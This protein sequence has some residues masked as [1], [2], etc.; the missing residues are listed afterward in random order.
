MRPTLKTVVRIRYI[1]YKHAAHSNVPW[2]ATNCSMEPIRPTKKE[3][4]RMVANYLLSI[5]N[6][7]VTLQKKER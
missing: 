2:I 6:L 5:L 3:K 4:E 1:I 7:S